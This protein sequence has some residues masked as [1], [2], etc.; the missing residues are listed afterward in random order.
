VKDFGGD[1]IATGLLPPSTQELLSAN[2]DEEVMKD[3][4]TAGGTIYAY[5][6]NG[7]FDVSLLPGQLGGFVT[8][9]TGA[10]VP[11]AQISVV[12]LSNGNTIT[13]TTDQTG[14]WVASN[15]P[16]GRFKVSA[17]MQGFKTYVREITNDANGPLNYSFR[18]SVGTVAET[19]EVTSGANAVDT[20]QAEKRDS[21][22]L[23]REA[24]QKA[25]EMQN[26]AS[27]YVG[28]LQ[29]RV[30]GVLP[31]RVDVPRTGN[32]YRFVRPLVLAEA[33][34]L[35]FSYNSNSR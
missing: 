19:V 15:I 28:N 35:T 20:M 3:V 24:K 34:R 22:R 29:Q 6:A 4:K 5:D 14:H 7:T 26:T 17:S 9:A 12:D 23:E 25:K 31:V 2:D 21:D 8:D 13:A 1:A 11:N 10:V 16:S 18:L 33:T 30:A 32:S 27:V